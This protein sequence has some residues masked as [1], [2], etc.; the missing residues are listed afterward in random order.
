MAKLFNEQHSYRMCICVSCLVFLFLMYHGLFYV[1]HSQFR[2][3]EKNFQTWRNGHIY[4][5]G[6]DQKLAHPCFK[7]PRLQGTS[8]IW[9]ET[10]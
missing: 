5:Q 2:I 8:Q 3:D 7:A 9:C 6:A 4:K 10:L 1:A